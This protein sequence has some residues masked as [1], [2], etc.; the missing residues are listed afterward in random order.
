[1]FAFS[2]AQSR[3]FH[4][5]LKVLIVSFEDGASVCQPVADSYESQSIPG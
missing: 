2:P 1:M 4:R 3:A 5:Q